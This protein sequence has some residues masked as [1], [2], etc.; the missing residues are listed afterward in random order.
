[1][2]LHVPPALS[3]RC[4]SAWRQC[5]LPAPRTPVSRQPPA[6]GNEIS[7]GKG[8][9]PYTSLRF[10]KR[11]FRSVSLSNMLPPAQRDRFV[12]LTEQNPNKT[13]GMMNKRTPGLRF[14]Q[15]RVSR[16]STTPITTST[17]AETT[18]SQAVVTVGVPRVVSG[19]TRPPPP[20]PTA[21]N[22]AAASPERA[23]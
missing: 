2:S 6:D 21:P 17:T 3:R 11:I 18:K 9:L 20:K 4:I 12:Q 15:S 16:R 13:F 10:S 7:R 5:D 14:P 22:T 23:R 8:R 19:A 1:M